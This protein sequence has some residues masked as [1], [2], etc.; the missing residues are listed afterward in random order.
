MTMMFLFRPSDYAHSRN[1]RENQKCLMR[2]ETQGQYHRELIGQ[3]TLQYVSTLPTVESHR[4][5]SGYI[6]TN[7]PLNLQITSLR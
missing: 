5:L 7:H 1:E 4:T 3:M 2:V 6:F